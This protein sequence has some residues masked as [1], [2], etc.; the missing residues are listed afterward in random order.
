MY[1]ITNKDV[2]WVSGGEYQDWHVPVISGLASGLA[3]G[4]IKAFQSGS[5]LKAAN[6]FIACSIPTAIASSL[7]VGSFMLWDWAMTE[8]SP[9][10]DATTV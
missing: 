8:S 9:A 2:S 3:F 1:E 10:D 5:L 7:I 6:Y 4:T